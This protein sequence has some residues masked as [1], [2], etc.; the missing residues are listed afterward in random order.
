VWVWGYAVRFIEIKI[1]KEK[2]KKKIRNGFMEFWLLY[3][4]LEN[5]NWIYVCFT[6]NV[7]WLG[8]E[9]G[10]GR[11]GEGGCMYI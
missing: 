3:G 7:E 11:G 4:N 8:C 6:L 10:R 5:E 1:R 2:K 9:R